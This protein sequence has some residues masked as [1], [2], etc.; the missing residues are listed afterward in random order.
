MAKTATDPTA[1]ME[2]TA[3]IILGWV[4]SQTRRTFNA[5][6]GP[7]RE[8][9]KGY[10]SVRE[11]SAD[12]GKRMIP[13]MTDIN[14]QIG[15]WNKTHE[16][17]INAGKAERRPELTLAAFARMFDPSVPTNPEW[18]DLP[19][20]ERVPGYK[21]HAAYYTLDYIRKEY[22]RWN[23]AQHGESK[24]RPAAGKKT[25][26]QARAFSLPMALRIIRAVLSAMTAEEQRNALKMIRKTFNVSEAGWTKFENLLKKS[27]PLAEVKGHIVFTKPIAGET[28]TKG[29][30]SGLLP[31]ERL[32]QKG[33][34]VTLSGRASQSKAS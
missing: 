3:S 1:K 29:I 22:Q 24:G 7:F 34:H 32:T 23:A 17:Q 9:V 5:V 12:V 2:N 6:S 15:K 26:G 11:R 25:D 14:A 8:L 28:T 13:L 27:T 30:K 19:S 16:T 33:Q 20:G 18:K 4:N 10:S 21:Q 31:S